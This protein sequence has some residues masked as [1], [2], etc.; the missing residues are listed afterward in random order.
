MWI[1]GESEYLRRGIIY[2]VG[3]RVFIFFG[4]WAVSLVVESV[5]EVLR[6]KVWGEWKKFGSVIVENGRWNWLEKFSIVRKGWGFIW[7]WWVCINK[8]V[9]SFCYVFFLV[10]YG[11]WRVVFIGSW[12]WIFFGLSFVGCILWKD[13][14]NLCWG[15]GEYR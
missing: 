9:Y 1:Y 3:Y 6:L 10:E 7:S 4:R 5:G 13:K 14:G 8:V 2:V 11:C 15:L 12:W